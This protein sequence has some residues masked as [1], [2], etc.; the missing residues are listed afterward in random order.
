MLRPVYPS[1]AVRAD[2]RRRLSNLIGRMADSIA[3]WMTAAYRANPP[4]TA[5]D[6]PLVRIEAMQV[7]TRRGHRWVATV[8]GERLV[9]LGG[10]VRTF[11][12]EAAAK[13]AARVEVGSYLPTDE[14]A[15]A[16]D[17]MAEEWQNRF[18]EAAGEL[19]AR[20][21]RSAQ[22]HSDRAIRSVLRR[23]GF[24][25]D[26]Q[27]T[28]AM[29][30]VLASTVAQNVALIRSIPQQYLTNVQG[31]VMRSVQQG[32]D[33]GYLTKYLK[34][35]RGVADRR[36][37]TIALSQNNMATAALQKARQVELGIEWAVWLHSHAGEEPRP[38]HLANDGKRYKVAEGW[39]DPDPKV[40]RHIWP[41]ELINCRC[42]QRA[43]M[44][45]KVEPVEDDE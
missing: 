4:E 37:R 23:S 26:L 6:A 8:D 35:Q 10:T 30:D 36:A 43:V 13:R 27:M 3:Y 7:P 16:F 20:F 25:V 19:A 41:G 31:A 24:A 5:E 22:A 40:R 2:Y 32:R 11:A 44:P 17:D 9:S 45:F 14:L 34:E 21:S 15:E 28:P 42:V 18:D 39:F 38:T 1:A 29:Q 12:T 33:V